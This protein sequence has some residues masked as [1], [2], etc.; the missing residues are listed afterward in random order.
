MREEGG[1][2]NVRDESNDPIF[3]VVELVGW[4]RGRW[5]MLVLVNHDLATGQDE[6]QR[7]KKKKGCS[8][9]STYSKPGTFRAAEGSDAPDQ[10]EF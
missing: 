8:F 3:I 1:G 6:K 2:D 9:P 4:Q 5:F 7:L 10:G